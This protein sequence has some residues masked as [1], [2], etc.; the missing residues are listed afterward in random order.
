ME[1]ALW[2]AIKNEIA[3]LIKKLSKIVGGDDNEFLK[4][5]Y[6]ELIERHQSNLMPLVYC[7]RTTLSDVVDN[8]CATK[9][10]CDVI[11]SNCKVCNYNP[12]FCYYAHNGTC[13][14]SFTKF[15]VEHF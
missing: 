6:T 13:S 7:L 1:R 2:I 9:A 4:S 5:Y 3:S 11:R 8:S 12:P 14:K 15:H 10:Q